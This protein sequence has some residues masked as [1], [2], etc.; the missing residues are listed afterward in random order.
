MK[1]MT[2][3]T[4][5]ALARSLARENH[6]ESISHSATLVRIPSIA[7][8]EG[9]AQ[10]HVAEHLSGLGAATE[11]LEP[12]TKALF[13][14][15]PHVA[16]CPTHLQHD[17]V[18]PNADPP[19]FEALQ[20]SSLDGVLNYTGRPNMVANLRGTGGGGSLI[21]NGHID[22]VTIEPT[23][24]WTRDPFGAEVED[25]LM[26]GRGTSDMRGGP[27]VAVMALICLKRAGAPEPLS[28]ITEGTGAG[29]RKVQDME[30]SH[31]R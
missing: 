7:G 11:S 24:E 10:R 16:Q 25:G 28:T 22:T 14:R 3:P 15:F 9:E 31:A 18:L 8:E 17:L 1:E 30:S 29:H 12:N 26:Y 23:A 2:T 21:L 19:N 20:A 5:K 27:M 13:A 6:A 4:P